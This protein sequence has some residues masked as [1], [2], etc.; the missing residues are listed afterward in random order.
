MGI[1]RVW[2]KREG[3]R[4]MAKAFFNGVEKN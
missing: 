2:K 4:N 1:I 3:A